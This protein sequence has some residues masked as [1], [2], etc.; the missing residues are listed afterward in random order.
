[1]SEVSS[2]K[3]RKNRIYIAIDLKSFYASV[4][5]VERGLDPLTTNLVVADVSR[6]EK[7]ICLAV[8][9]SLKA[10]GLSGRSRLFE[11]EQKS[12]EIERMTGKKLTYIAAKPRMALYI[13][14]S[15]RIYEVYLKYISHEDISVYSI[16]EVFMDVTDYLELY[17][18]TAH[19]LAMTIVKDVLHTTGITATV[20]IANNLYLCKVAMDILAKH[21]QADKDGVRIAELDE[22]TF[23]KKYWDYKPLT[24]FWRTGPGTVKRLNSNGM[25]TWGD[26]ARMSISNEKLLYKLFGVDAEILIDHAWGYEPCTIKD[27]KAYK[28]RTNSLSHGQVLSRPYSYEQARTVIKE[29]VESL[30]QDMIVKDVTSSSFTI[31]IMY[32]RLS[33]DNGEYEGAVCMDH[34]GRYVPEPVHGTVG[35][36]TPTSSARIIREAIVELFDNIVDHDLYVRRMNVCANN[37]STENYVQL[38][39]FTDQ[40]ALEKEKKVQKA[41]MNIQQRFGK[42]AVLKGT[43]LKEGATTR[44]RNGQIGGHKA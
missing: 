16:D 1:M 10:Y 41:M 35:L 36:T 20:G 37:V 25:L 44:E 39:L 9:P 38:D 34:Y 26:V 22:I 21:M 27:I 11:V 4:E 2:K 32:D 19:E 30:V 43:D 7:T 18:Q 6:T 24:D 29:M 33:I 8:T 23:R 17:H 12:K 31:N 14:Y 28:P 5:C 3:D 13:D 15:T 40:D 42:N